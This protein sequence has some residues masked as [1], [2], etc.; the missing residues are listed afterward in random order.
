MALITVMLCDW[1]FVLNARVLVLVWVL[2]L[3]VLVLVL[4]LEKQ[5][6]ITSLLDSPGSFSGVNSSHHIIRPAPY[7]EL[8]TD[9]IPLFPFH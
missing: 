3:W 9:P 7:R 6:L 5:V 2:K 1:V 8:D 4:V